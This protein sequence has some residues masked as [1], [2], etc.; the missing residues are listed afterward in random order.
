[1][2]AIASQR[3]FHQ[4]LIFWIG[5]IF[6]LL[7]SSIVQFAIIWWVTIEYQ[8]ELYLGIAA[9]LSMGVFVLLAPFAGVLVDRWNRKWLIATADFL[10]AFVT[11]ILL[12]IFK[13]TTIPLWSVFLILALKGTF[14][15]FHTPAVR[16]LI[17]LMI[18]KK[19]LN[20]MNSI[21][22][23]FNGVINLV[24]PLIGA[25]LLDLFLRTYPIFWIDIGTFLLAIIPL[26][27]IT[28]PKTKEEGEAEEE[29]KIAV[30]SYTKELREIF[31][32]I[33]TT[34]GL[35][36]LLLLATILNF[37]ITPVNTLAPY[38]I[39][40]DHLGDSYQLAYV[41][42]F[43]YG[44]ILLGGALM[45]ILRNLKNKMLIVLVF[46]Y[47]G[48]I[49]Y[50]ILAVAPF[51]YFWILWIGA[52]IFGVAMPIVNVI[53]QTIFQTTVPLSMQGR[54]QAVAFSLSVAAMPIS[55]LVSGAIAEQIGIRLVLYSCIVIG[56]IV[57]TSMWLFTEL[58]HVGTEITSELKLQK[59][60][61]TTDINIKK[62]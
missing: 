26:L 30:T 60:E 48:F 49:G 61:E 47:V 24:G 56:V 16:S 36:S 59:M 52:I 5:Q 55:M 28:I 15:A 23:I 39:K 34:R 18:P 35:L 57:T 38:Y 10:Q 3:S 12:L 11:L 37:L 17:P 58:K 27:V 46:I 19:N 54:F 51:G 8:S 6:S 20:Q 2:N 43:Y 22:F 9:F 14:Q 4:Y 40:F 33:R 21:N 45:L 42:A 7:G 32:F 62:Y 25:F 53:T 31:N 41:F 44:G 13:Y 50:L 1:M 29:E